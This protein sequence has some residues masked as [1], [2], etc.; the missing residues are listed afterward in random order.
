MK[1]CLFNDLPVQVGFGSGAELSIRAFI[2]E[3]VRRG[4]SVD[5]FTAQTAN[6]PFEGYDLAVVKNVM[7][8]NE[9]QL[10][11][12]LKL[13]VIN[14]P[15]DYHHCKWR[16]FY[17]ML[18]KCRRCRGLIRTNALVLGAVLNVFLSPLHRE[19]YEHVIP[20]LKHMDNV[21]LS[22]PY[23]NPS[24]FK[25]VRGVARN[26]NTCMGVNVLLSF[27]GA[28]RAVQFAREHPEMTFN[29]FGGAGDG[30]EDRLPENAFYMGRVLQEALPAL[31]SQASH[32]LELPNTPQPC[33]RVPFEAAL[34]GVKRFIVNRNVG[35][36]SYKWMRR[37][38]RKKVRRNMDRA[39][40]DLLD[41][42]EDLI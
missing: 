39:L 3:A 38:S 22:P 31:Y 35:A 17:P 14:W 4:H 15:S 16:L 10:K 9:A 23:V 5:C 30:W 11:E 24:L 33:N 40:P 32:L 21:H 28:Q 25:P 2:D 19:A 41:A 18:D 8:F 7:S 37:P 36:F 13:P 20:E 1:I 26:E 27:K 34:C 29:F 42:L 6:R 12:I